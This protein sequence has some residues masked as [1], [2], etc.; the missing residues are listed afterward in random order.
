MNAQ[1]LLD[2]LDNPEVVTMLELGSPTAEITQAFQEAQDRIDHPITEPV[3]V[4][5][6]T[7]DLER[8]A[9][10]NGITSIILAT[11]GIIGYG[12]GLLLEQSIIE[13]C[14]MLVFGIGLGMF[15]TTTRIHRIIDGSSSHRP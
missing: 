11:T 13:Q 2:E 12:T 3:T 4:R 5:N 10:T 8:L 1:E 7:F 6:V 9:T 15:L 14:S